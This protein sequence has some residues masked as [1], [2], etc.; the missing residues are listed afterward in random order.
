MEAHNILMT[1]AN[2][3]GQEQATDFRKPS[4]HYATLSDRVVAER[5]YGHFHPLQTI[6][7]WF[8]R[9]IR[10]FLLQPIRDLHQTHDRKSVGRDASPPE[11]VIDSQSIKASHAKKRGWRSTSNPI[12]G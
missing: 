7:L 4:I 5:C 8:R 10:S 12:V 9:V 6:Y 2:R 3:V 1:P 11:C